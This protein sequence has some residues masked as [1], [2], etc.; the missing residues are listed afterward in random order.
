MSLATNSVLLL[1]A[2]DSP[3]IIT[4]ALVTRFWLRVERKVGCWGWKG[5]KAGYGY[6]NVYYNRQLMLR[7]HRLSWALAN[8]PIPKGLKVLHKCDNPPCT[9]PDHLFL[10]TDKDNAHDRMRK[11]RPGSHYYRNG[12]KNPY[13][14][15]TTEKVKFIRAVYKPKEIVSSDLAWL[16]GV[17]STTIKLIIRRIAWSHVA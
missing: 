4:P 9:N 7:A 17:S 8:G 2:E 6:G 1:I 3:L 11:G 14:H 12:E 16:F 13:A 10:G 5:G 15:L